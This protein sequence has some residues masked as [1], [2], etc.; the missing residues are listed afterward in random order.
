[1]GNKPTGVSTEKRPR[2]TSYNVCYTKLLRRA[3]GKQNVLFVVTG[4]QPAVNTPD[5]LAPYNIPSGKFDAQ[6]VSA[7]LNAY[8]M[9]LY[10]Q[11]TWVTGYFGQQFYLNHEL[12]ENSRKSLW[13]V[14]KVAS[15]FLSEFA[16]VVV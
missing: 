15:E 4:A 14:Q 11:G 12:I 5:D 16:G 2:I 9:A 13:D 3:V 8:L 10:G 1:M 6:R 7:L